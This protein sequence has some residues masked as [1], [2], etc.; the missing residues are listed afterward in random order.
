ARMI[1]AA[2]VMSI[3]FP[4]II[5]WKITQTVNR[6]MDVILHNA[7]RPDESAVRTVKHLHWF[8]DTDTIVEVYQQ[9]SDKDR[10]ERL[11]RVYKEITGEDISERLTAFGDLRAVT[12][13]PN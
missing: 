8:A 2:A 12:P 11:A 3:A 1:V 5:Q 6:S 9:E 4:L 7:V 10:Q 13:I